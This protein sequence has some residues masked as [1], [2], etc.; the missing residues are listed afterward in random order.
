MT[1]KLELQVE[2]PVFQKQLVPMLKLQDMQVHFSCSAIVQQALFVLQL[3]K[4]LCCG[5]SASLS[6]G[7]PTMLSLTI[8]V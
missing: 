4:S 7:N 2:V 5:K 8:Q 6:T 3:H 1:G